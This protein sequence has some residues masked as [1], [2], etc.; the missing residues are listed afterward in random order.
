MAHCERCEDRYDRIVP[1]TEDEWG[2]VLCDDCRD[3]LAEAAAE[4]RQDVVP[5]G[6]QEQYEKAVHERQELR[7]RD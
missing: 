4:R 6:I 1:A 5:Q 7:R 2:R 3:A